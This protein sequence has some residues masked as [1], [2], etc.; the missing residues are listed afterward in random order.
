MDNKTQKHLNNLRSE[1]RDLQIT[2]TMGGQPFA[3]YCRFY[4]ESD[5]PVID[6]TFAAREL[7]MIVYD[8]PLGPDSDYLCYK[9]L[10]IGRSQ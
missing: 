2:V 4:S 8:E 9:I 5:N 7:A 1:D 3:V 10:P 6:H